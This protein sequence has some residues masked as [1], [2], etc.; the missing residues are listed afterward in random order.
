MRGVSL[1]FTRDS[2]TVRKRVLESLSSLY[3]EGSSLYPSQHSY[4][5][6]GEARVQ[7]V[8]EPAFPYLCCKEMTMT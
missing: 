7:A 3:M 2:W 8:V 5:L 1:D 6:F 4:P